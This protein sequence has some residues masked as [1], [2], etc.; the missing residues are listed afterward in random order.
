MSLAAGRQVEKHLV[1]LPLFTSVPLSILGVNCG[2]PAPGTIGYSPEE[3]HGAPV[4]VAN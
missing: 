2:T 4:D 1:D 3:F